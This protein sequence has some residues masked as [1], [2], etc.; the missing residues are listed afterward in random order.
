MQ[1]RRHG[2]SPRLSAGGILRHSGNGLKG[3]KRIVDGGAGHV[4]PYLNI[5]EKLVQAS[6][7]DFAHLDVIQ[8]GAQSSELLLSGISECSDRSSGNDMQ[9]S[10]G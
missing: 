1:F 3:K 9:R 6:A 2:L 5:V 7:D 8:F 4:Q 10:L